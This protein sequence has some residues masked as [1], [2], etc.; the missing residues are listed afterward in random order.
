M[1]FLS[2]P[3]QGGLTAA[4]SFYGGEKEAVDV[5]HVCVHCNHLTEPCMQLPS[6]ETHSRP[7]HLQLNTHHS[8]SLSAKLKAVHQETE[9]MKLT[10][11]LKEMHNEIMKY[12]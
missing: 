2:L 8:Q 6:K 7:D 10:S 9:S 1:S 4:S 3:G 11:H 12:T 5:A